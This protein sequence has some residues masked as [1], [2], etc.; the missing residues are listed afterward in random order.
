LG[1]DQTLPADLVLRYGF[2]DFEND[3]SY[4]AANEQI[5]ESAFVF[6]PPARVQDWKYDSE[7]DTFVQA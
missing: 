2:C 3:G 5:I 6:S 1:E 4:N 7:E